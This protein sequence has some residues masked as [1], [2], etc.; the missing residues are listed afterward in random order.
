MAFGEP[1]T[2]DPNPYGHLREMLSGKK[3]AF[4][5]DGLQMDCNPVGITYS[6]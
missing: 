1:P 6:I 3:N 2:D 5:G 4:N